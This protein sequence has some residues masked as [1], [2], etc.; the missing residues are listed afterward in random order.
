MILHWP[1]ITMIVLGALSLGIHMA[2]HGEQRTD[3]YGAFGMLFTLVL[4]FW[5]MYEGGFFGAV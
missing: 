4:E 3:K 5:L 1:Q 2:K